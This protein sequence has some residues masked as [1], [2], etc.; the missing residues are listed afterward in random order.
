MKDITSFMLIAL[1]MMAFLYPACAQGHTT[2]AA[3]IHNNMHIDD[4]L[5]LWGW[6]QN[7]YGE[8]GQVCSPHKLL[9][10][11]CSILLSLPRP[12]LRDVIYVD[13]ATLSNF[14][15]VFK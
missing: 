7:L 1:A 11:E 6:G 10:H 9:S 4:E 2:L 5:T 3:G 12:Y 8:L 15:V 14:P 13:I